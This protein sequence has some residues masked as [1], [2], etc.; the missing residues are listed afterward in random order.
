MPVRFVGP[1]DAIAEPA[2]A[3]ADRMGFKGG[4]GQLLIVTEAPA[5]APLNG[6][7]VSRGT[8][9]DLRQL[10]EISVIAG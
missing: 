3:W 4:P 10:P 8:F 7:T 2:R 9:G 6:G 1:D 5:H